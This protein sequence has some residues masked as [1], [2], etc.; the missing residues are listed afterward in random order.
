MDH[1]YYLYPNGSSYPTYPLIPLANHPAA[2]HFISWS[3]LLSITMNLLF[4]GNLC[5]WNHTLHIIYVF[6]LTASCHQVQIAFHYEY[7]WHFIYPLLDGFRGCF[8]LLITVNNSAMNTGIQ[9]TLWQCNGD[10]WYS[11]QRISQD[12]MKLNINSGLF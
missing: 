8:H 6:L 2:P 9:I 11:G 1:L 3:S 5:K 10:T 7:P 4:P 12:R